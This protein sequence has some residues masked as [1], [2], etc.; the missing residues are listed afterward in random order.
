MRYFLLTLSIFSWFINPTFAADTVAQVT[1]HRGQAE[2]FQ[3]DQSRP[4]HSQDSI[5]WQ[6]LIQTQQDSRLHITFEDGTLL[7]LGDHSLIKI[8]EFVYDPNVENNAL[9][10]LTQG[11]FRMVTGAL[12]KT[13]D[14]S[15][16]VKTPLVTIGIRGTDF[17]GLQT[18]DQLTLALLD[19][20]RL[21]VTTRDGHQETLTTPLSALVIKVGEPVQKITL[22]PEQVEEA[23]KT[24]KANPE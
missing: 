8:D 19:D 2:A 23:K 24:I 13:A 5:L 22:T 16:S 14:A 1:Y 10:T 7:Q 4:L 18:A 11:V 15:F 9:F 3:P 6:D 20:G 21:D 12:N 17:W